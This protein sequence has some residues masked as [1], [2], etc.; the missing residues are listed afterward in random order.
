MTAITS[1]LKLTGAKKK[2]LKYGEAGRYYYNKFQSSTRTSQQGH[3]QAGNRPAV[4]ISNN[5]FNAKSN[6]TIVCPITNTDNKYPLHVPLDDRTRTR[7]VILCEHVRALDITARQYKIAEHL[8]KDI[9]QEV[10]NIVYSE[11]E[12]LDD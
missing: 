2:V 6:M 11:I 5:F 9:L 7:G 3:E 4:V 12:L 1:L 8:P 10:I